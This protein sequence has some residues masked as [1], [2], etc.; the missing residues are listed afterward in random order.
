M[1]LS[2]IALQHADDGYSRRVNM[3]GF[4]LLTIRFEEEEKKKKFYFA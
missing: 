2:G 3:Y 1:I 4:W